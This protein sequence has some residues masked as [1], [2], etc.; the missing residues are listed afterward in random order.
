M[1]TTQKTLD[2]NVG[3]VTT[4]ICLQSHDRDITHELC[5]ILLPGHKMRVQHNEHQRP[6]Q[7]HQR[8]T[9]TTSGVQK[10]RLG[11]VHHTSEGRDVD[12]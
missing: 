8:T 1:S 7:C 11:F 9:N 4:E 12:D 6:P 2:M 3:R 10:A 5:H